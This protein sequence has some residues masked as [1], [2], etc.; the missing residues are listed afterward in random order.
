VFRQKSKK[1]EIPIIIYQMGKVGSTAL[2][3][4]LRDIWD[5][6]FQV[7]TLIPEHIE[8]IEKSLLRNGLGRAAHLDQSKMVLDGYLLPGKEVYCLCPVRSPLDR[9]LSAF[10]QELANRVLM[11]KGLSE[12]LNLTGYITLLRKIPLNNN[13]KNLIFEY[14]ASNR[15]DGYIEILQH[16]FVTS[17]PHDLPLSWCDTELRRATGIDVLDNFDL[18][19]GYSLHKKD[20]IYMLVYKSE[21][22]DAKKATALSEFLGVEVPTIRKHHKSSNK[23]YGDAHAKFKESL[24][25]STELRERYLRSR[26]MKT[27]YPEVT[28]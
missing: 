22:S 21:I 17:Y 1:R 10:F 18:E 23:R 2:A 16:Y 9:N 27:F 25:L 20:N 11:N 4:T 8:Q 5:P 6:V 19:K 12:S 7:H 24:N 14:M 26:Y 3:S 13:W 28:L 15:L